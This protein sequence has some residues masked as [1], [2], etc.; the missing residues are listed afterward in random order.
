MQ[1]KLKKNTGVFSKK[2]KEVEER[3][4]D[5]DVS[6]L[7]KSVGDDEGDVAEEE[8]EKEM[9]TVIKESKEKPSLLD[10]ME[11]EDPFEVMLMQIDKK[12]DFALAQINSLRTDLMEYN[13]LS[14]TFNEVVEKMASLAG[15]VEGM[16]KGQVTVQK[17]K[18]TSQEKKEEPTNEIKKEPKQNNKIK[19]ELTLWVNKLQKKKR[20]TNELLELLAERLKTTPEEVLG[21]LEE[22]GEVSGTRAKWLD[23]KGNN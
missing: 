13:T 14:A 16:A 11:M 15:V 5:L 7:L 2:E 12:M 3:G 18:E 10:D 21:I 20:V 9:K 23:K 6:E 17:I 8:E 22:V 19:E 1:L 4:E